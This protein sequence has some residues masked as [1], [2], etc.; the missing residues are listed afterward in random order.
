MA[1]HI[2]TICRQQPTN[3]LSV[4]EHL[5]GLAPKG[6]KVNSKDAEVTFIDI[7]PVFL[8]LT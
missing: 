6:L 3:C 4:F 1:K 8:L 2:Q 7:V 5:V